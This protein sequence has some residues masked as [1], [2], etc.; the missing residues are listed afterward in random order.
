MMLLMM[1]PMLLPSLLLHVML[2][3]LPGATTRDGGRT[4][5]GRDGADT[6]TI[7]GAYSGLIGCG[8][9]GGCG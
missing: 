7:A 3:P 9:G 8:G 4:I 5:I 1:L 6:D 2:L